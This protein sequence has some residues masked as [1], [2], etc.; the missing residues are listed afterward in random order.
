M[1]TR[2]LIS[3]HTASWSLIE[4]HSNTSECQILRGLFEIRWSI[5]DFGVDIVLAVLVLCC[6]RLNVWCVSVYRFTT[7]FR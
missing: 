2:R 5:K 1:G 3:A 4:S 6:C 7:R